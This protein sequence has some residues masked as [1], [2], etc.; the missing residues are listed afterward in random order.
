MREAALP[1]NA[2]ETTVTSCGTPLTVPSPPNRVITNDTVTTELLFGFY[3]RMVGHTTYDD[4][5]VAYQ[6]SPC[7][8]DLDHIRSLGSGFTREIPQ[9]ADPD[10]TFAGWNYR[11]QRICRRTT[12]L[13]H[14]VLTVRYIS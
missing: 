14:I 4:K 9:N 7:R 5:H 1:T 10:L 2:R 8:S 6:A 12:R 11:T 3:D 13:Y